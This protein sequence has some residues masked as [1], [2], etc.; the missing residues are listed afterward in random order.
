MEISIM[1]LVTIIIC[2]FVWGWMMCMIIWGIVFK[3][4]SEVKIDLPIVAIGIA[5][6]SLGWVISRAVF[7]ILERVLGG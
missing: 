5:S 6:F 7:I 3:K 2:S 1:Q 4:F